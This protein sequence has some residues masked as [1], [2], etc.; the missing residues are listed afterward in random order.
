MPAT[1]EPI[2]TYTLGTAAP[3]LTF[4]S[5]PATYTD[6]VMVA[7]V[8]AASVGTDSID[9]QFNSDTAT[10]YSV[11]YINGNGTTA[12]SVR[13]SGDTKIIGAIISS[14]EVSTAIWH[15][16]NYANATTYKSAFARGGLGS[17]YGVRQAVGL[18]RSTSAINT[19]KL[20][21]DSS[22]NFAAGSIFTL[23]GIKAA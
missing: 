21:N 8:T 6:L 23:Y 10:N 5:I 15:I 4:S 17:S 11:T 12:T 13:F 22:Q 16:M 20:Y 3:S 9:M 18:W 14:T 7:S 19:I 1:Y 2:A